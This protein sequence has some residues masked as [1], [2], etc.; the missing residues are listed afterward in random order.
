MLAHRGRNISH[1]SDQ[2]RELG[3]TDHG[4]ADDKLGIAH[5]GRAEDLASR[6]RL[7]PSQNL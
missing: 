1:L 7:T 3:A 4:P 6:V 5:E 2:V